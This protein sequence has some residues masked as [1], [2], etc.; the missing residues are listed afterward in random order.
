MAF[1]VGL[2]NGPVFYVITLDQ[3]ADK[4]NSFRETVK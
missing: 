1:Y 2:P 3:Q 4:G